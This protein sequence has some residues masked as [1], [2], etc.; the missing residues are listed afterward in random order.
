MSAA[1][2]CSALGSWRRSLPPRLPR[3]TW[4]SEGT[5]PGML[6]RIARHEWRIMSAENTPWLILLVLALAVGYAVANG[7]HWVAFQQT[8]LQRAFDE[9][10][11]RYAG[12]KQQ[13]ID[14]DTGRQRA[15]FNDPRMPAAAGRVLAWRYPA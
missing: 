8:T 11:R 4:T 12:L 10:A 9:E 3:S 2:P 7:I 5:G 13:V 6:S 1:S 15:P 14:I